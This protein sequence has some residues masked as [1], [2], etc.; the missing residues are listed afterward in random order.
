MSTTKMHMT[1]SRLSGELFCEY[2]PQ[3]RLDSQRIDELVERLD[4]HD[5]T[6]ILDF[7]SDAQKRLTDIADDM[8][9][10]VKTKDSGEAGQLLSDMV[11]ILKGF[12]VEERKLREK[13]DLWKRLIGKAKQPLQ[14]FLQRFADVADQID[15]I[16]NA[17]ESRKQ[18]LLVD[19]VALDRLYEATLEYYRDLRHH[20]AAA[21]Q[22][23][24]RAEVHSLP[25]LKARA[26][27]EDS[28]ESAQSLRDFQGRRNELERRLH[29]LELTRQVTMQALPSIRMIQ[30][31]D[32]SLVGKIDTTLINTVPLWRQQL[33]Q[34]IAIHRSGKAAQAM[35]DSADLTNALLRENAETLQT[36]NRESRREHERGVFDIT[37]VEEANRILIETI[38]ESIHLH[39]QARIRRKDAQK[40]L[41]KAERTLRDTLKSASTDRSG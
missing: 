31:N 4:I 18:Q 22:V 20:I 35:K 37:A 17:L 12:Q 3:D 6:S 40:R 24:E 36:A 11:L 39:E 10:N 28:M 41:D 34:S 27:H 8:L 7:G 13:P 1:D 26:E 15:Q 23:I 25:R 21:E 30:E 5:T 16:S 32:K 19:V 9:E 14:A 2:P 29:D 33:A 38:E